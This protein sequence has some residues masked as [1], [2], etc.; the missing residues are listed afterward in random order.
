LTIPAEWMTAMDQVERLS[1]H[2]D[3][4][5]LEL[6]ESRH[7]SVAD[8]PDD[9][10]TPLMGWRPKLGARYVDIA[11]LHDAVR[12][13]IAAAQEG[14]RADVP[15]DI[16]A[17]YD[18]Y[19]HLSVWRDNQRAK[20]MRERRESYRLHAKRICE[21]YAIVGMEDFDLSKV[22]RTKKRAPEDGDSPLHAEAR[23]QRQRAALYEFRSELA[24]QAQKTGTEIVP[25][26]GATTRHCRKCVEKTGQIDRAQRTWTCEHCG[27][28]W[29]QDRNA[30]E[31]IRD[32]AVGGSSAPVATVA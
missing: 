5:T 2:I 20:L 14:V 31:N 15:E 18:R 6:A 1:S 13:R 7:E 29:D 11:G 10:R 28:V 22:A 4:H 8:L 19:R 26:K 21:Q 27:A 24:R 30:A 12:A 3:K 16:R 9:L 23:S 25:G 32:T 17:W